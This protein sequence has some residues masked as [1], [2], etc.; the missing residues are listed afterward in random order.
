MGPAHQLTVRA[1]A[2]TQALSLLALGSSREATQALQQTRE[3]FANLGA[4]PALAGADALLERAT[5]L[6]S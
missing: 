1:G 5:A 6:S 2:W 3:I 4:R